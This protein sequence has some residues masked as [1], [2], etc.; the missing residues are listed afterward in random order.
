MGTRYFRKR[1]LVIEANQWFCSTPL[2]LHTPE[3]NIKTS[4]GDWII[5]GIN[6]EQYPCKPDV[7]YKTYIPVCMQCKVVNLQKM[8]DDI[9][10]VCAEKGPSD[11]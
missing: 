8:S 5:T 7:F 3:G 2:I 4:P 9:C 6:G 11:E 1:P 10:V